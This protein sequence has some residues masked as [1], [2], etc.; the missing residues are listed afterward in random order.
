MKTIRRS[1][2]IIITIL[3][4][5]VNSTLAYR[6]STNYIIHSDSINVG[7]V[8]ENSTNYQME[9]TIG[10]VGTGE[11]ASSSYRLK[12]GFQQMQ[13]VVISITS[14][15][16]VNMSPNIGGVS[17]GTGA[18]SAT[19]T[20][21][22][23]SPAGYTLSIKAGTS[24]ALK[25][26]SGGCNVSVDSFADYTPAGS[27]PDYN[28]GIDNVDS[29]FGFNP[30]NSTDQVQNFQNDSSN[31]NTGSSINDEKCWYKFT[32]S[33]QSIAQSS[34]PNQ[35]S[36]SS[37]KVNLKATSGSSHLQVEGTYQATITVTAVTN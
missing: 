9:G 27:V 29:E 14:P 16:D 17:G 3:F 8:N 10:E 22:T 7:G 34:S 2:F 25:C 23:D 31:C 13:E 36:G 28:W 24:P 15:S 20:V 11:M 12:G 5:G 26:V 6:S 35:P 1:L 37:T 4:F 19:W 30:Y 21:T 32:T 18:G 33:D